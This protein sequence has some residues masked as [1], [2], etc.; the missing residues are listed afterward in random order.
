MATDG[1]DDVEADV[2]TRDRPSEPGTDRARP[3]QLSV[4]LFVLAGLVCVILVVGGTTRL[5]E[6]GL[7]IVKWDPVTGVVPP[8]SNAAWQ[9]EFDAYQATPEY[10]IINQGMTLGEFKRIFLWEYLHRLLGRVLGIAMAG[11]FFWFLAKRAIPRGYRWRLGGLVLLIG[12]QGAIGWWMVASGLVDRPDVAHKRLALHLV[13]ALILL[14]ALVWTAMDLGAL[15]AKREPVA[16]RPKA[17]FWP[18]LVL[19][20]MQ[21]TLGAFVAGL[22]AGHM[23]T[24]WPTMMGKWAPEPLTS[25]RPVWTNAIDNP[26]TVQFLHRW[27]AMVVAT[28][29]VVVAIRLYRAGAVARAVALV[30]AVLLQV[31]LGV[32]TLLNSVPIPLGVAHQSGAVLLLLVTIVAGHWSMGGARRSQISP[33][34]V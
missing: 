1:V 26:A 24:T 31:L 17:W 28:F 20:T 5:T 22:N 2:G 23:Y 6:S 34:D 21:I 16:G 30:A 13:T 15:A 25:L 3:G 10:R 14:C 9:T 8:L 19:L 33:G 18:F 12:L 27:L 4:W 29:A 7:S 11:P 32:L